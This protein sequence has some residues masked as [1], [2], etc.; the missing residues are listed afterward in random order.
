MIP[1]S[2]ALRKSFF[3]PKIASKPEDQGA[4]TSQIAAITRTAMIR[5]QIGRRAMN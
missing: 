5:D 4:N 1:F 2:T 3:L